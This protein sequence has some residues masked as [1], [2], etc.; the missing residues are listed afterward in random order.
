MAELKTK[1][2]AVSVDSFLEG[3]V[4]AQ[5]R[6]DA[7]TILEMMKEI[8][9]EPPKMWGPSIVG[10]GEYHY[11]YASGHEG[12]ICLTGFSPRKSALTLYFSCVLDARFAAQVRRNSAKPKRA[13]DASISRN[14]PMSIL[15]SFARYLKRI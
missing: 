10:F 6:A 5:R 14:S 1:P 8:T 3:V 12:D 7:Y 15:L 9:S 2:T 11:V 13:R 4:D